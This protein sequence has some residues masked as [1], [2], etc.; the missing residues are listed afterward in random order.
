MARPR[1][2]EQHAVVTAA[3]GV[4]WQRG[5]EGAA[6][7]DLEDATGLSRSSIYLAFDTKRGLFD[8]ALAEYNDSFIASMLGPMEAPGAGLREAAGFFRALAKLFREPQSQ[9]GCLMVNSIGELA[10]RDPTFTAPAARFVV[11][12]KAAFANALGGAAAHGAMSNRE[13]TRR[14]QMLADATIGAWLVVRA[15]PIAA[16]AS[17]RSIAAEIASWARSEGLEPGV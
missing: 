1:S 14:S 2:Y 4:F 13:A 6:V 8:A 12:L 11:R 5:L 15:D 7:S 16:V 17:C 3:K 10:G 9:R